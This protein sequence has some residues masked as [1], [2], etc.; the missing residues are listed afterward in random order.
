VII[1]IVEGQGDE[2]ALP[3]LARKLL[4][5]RAAYPTIETHRV[6]RNRVVKPGELEKAVEFAALAADCSGV[7]VVLDADEDC[8][9]I[10]GPDLAARAAAAATHKIVGVALANAEFESWALAGI[11]G[12]RGRRGIDP[13]AVWT[14]DPDAV[15]SPKGALERL[16]RGRSYLETDD[17]AAFAELLNPEHARRT[18]RSFRKFEKELLRIAGLPP[19]AGT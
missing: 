16:M 19:E 17:Q 11:E 7:L 2:E 10:L 5:A 3:V 18:S 1:I 12:L 6:K 15:R 9:A 8:P 4:R 13:T 14:G